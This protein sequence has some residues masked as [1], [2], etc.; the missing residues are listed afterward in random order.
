M[1]KQL[2]QA[3]LVTLFLTILTGLAYP[4]GMYGVSRILFPSQAHGSLVMK[5]G[6]VVGS[7]LIGQ[8][9]TSPGYFHGRPSATTD[10]DPKDPN[11]QVPA[12]YNAASSNASNAAPTAKSLVS[13]VSDR[14]KALRNE[15]PNAHVL[16]PVDLVTASGSGLDPH[17]SPVSAEYQIPRIAAAR[18]IS[19][20]DL[21]RLVDEETTGRVLGLLG[22]ATVNVLTINLVLDER[23]PMRAIS[24]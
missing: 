23:Y 24:R 20:E 14:V 7:T 5:D 13:D 21:R 1:F 15:N 8:N 9:F 11:K 12:P 6:K 18:G 22:K 16:V 17:I 10:T 3:V 4:L 2:K 19:E